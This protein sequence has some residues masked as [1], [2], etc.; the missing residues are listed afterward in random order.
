M[1]S[2][3]KRWSDTIKQPWDEYEKRLGTWI[4]CS[5]PSSSLYPSELSSSSSPPSSSPQS[6]SRKD[7]SSREQNQQ[8]LS[9]VTGSLSFVYSFVD[10]STCIDVCSLEEEEFVICCCPC[11]HWCWWLGRRLSCWRLGRHVKS[12]KM[13][14]LPKEQVIVHGIQ[15]NRIH[16][17][18]SPVLTSSG[19]RLSLLQLTLQVALDST[20]GTY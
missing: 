20:T 8:Y 5:Y 17:M 1:V 11:R 13:L 16:I 7:K 2:I 10:D 15:G 18:K 3:K 19:R 12:P 14:S 6:A 9:L 4:L